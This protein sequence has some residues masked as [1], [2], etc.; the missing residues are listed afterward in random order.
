MTTD[1]ST[2]MLDLPRT[3]ARS[4]R[5][6][7]ARRDGALGAAVRGVALELTGDV[8]VTEHQRDLVRAAPE[9]IGARGVR[10]RAQQRSSRVEQAVHRGRVQAADAAR[11]LRVR[12][13]ATREQ[14]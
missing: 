13:G 14:Q 12:V 1:S 8:G 11:V 6:V 2:L 7:S 4:Y 10:A 9:A 5:A 3:D